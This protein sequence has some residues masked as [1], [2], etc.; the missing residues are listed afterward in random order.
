MKLINRVKKETYP[1]WAMVKAEPDFFEPTNYIRVKVKKPLGKQ[2]RL[3]V[4]GNAINSEWHRMQMPYYWVGN[5]RFT[6]REP[7]TED[8]C[9]RLV[10]LKAKVRVPELEARHEKDIQRQQKG[11][12]Q[13]LKRRN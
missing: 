2:S 9:E 3:K 10:K 8:L 13:E 4:P 5:K 1:L 12:Y 11:K 7:I 6:I